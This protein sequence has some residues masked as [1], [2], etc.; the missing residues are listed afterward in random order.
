MS[1][2]ER[3]RFWVPRFALH[4]FISCVMTG[5]RHAFIASLGAAQC[6]LRLLTPSRG[7]ALWLTCMLTILLRTSRAATLQ[8][9]LAAVHSPWW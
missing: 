4:I 9:A 3:A 1:T 6:P 2:S 7:S 5:Q 8:L